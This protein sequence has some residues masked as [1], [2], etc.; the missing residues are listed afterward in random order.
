MLSLYNTLLLAVLLIGI[1]PVSAL[2]E[3]SMIL[4]VN[5]ASFLFSPANWVGDNGRGGKLYRESWYNGAYFICRW[6]TTDTVPSA[7]LLISNQTPGSAVSYY[8]D[9]NLIDNVSVPSSGGIR[10]EGLHGSG[11]HELTVIL[12][13]SQQMSRWNES[14]A[15]I[16]EGL[17]VDGSASPVKMPRDKKWVLIIGDSIT[18]GIQANNGNDSN[19]C[20]Y[21]FLIG[22]GLKRLGYAYCVSAC[23]FSG[24]IRPGDAGGDVPAYYSVTNGI[25]SA[26]RSRW[27]RIDEKTSLLD[28]MGHISGYGETGQ[29]PDAIVI[30]YGTNEALSSSNL[31]DFKASISKGLAALQN[32]AP[33]AKIII[34]IPFGL[35]NARIYPGGVQYIQAIKDAVY[36]FKQS[37]PSGKNAEILDLGKD[38]ANALA[39]PAYGGSVHPNAAGHAFI[40]SNLLPLLMME[41]KGTVD[42]NYPVH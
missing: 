34:C 3:S 9:G 11:L 14:N 16:I 40:A 7:T 35:G 27:N 13:N 15:C 37:H 26:E 18:E 39:S 2:A 36:Q 42:S 22:E 33:Q 5:S 25:Y 29:E 31:S 19:L 1:F 24:W 28:R 20:D 38:V 4:P 30:N 32:A 17:Q 6:T 21:S 10:I 41:L 8:M 23:G 12:R